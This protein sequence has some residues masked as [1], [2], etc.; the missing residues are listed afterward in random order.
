MHCSW[1]LLKVLRWMSVKKK[2]RILKLF[3]VSYLAVPEDILFPVVL[4]NAIGIPSLTMRLEAVCLS[5][6]SQGRLY[7]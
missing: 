4:L 2:D 5:S 6:L 1:P 3:V 7:F